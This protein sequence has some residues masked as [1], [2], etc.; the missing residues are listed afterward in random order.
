MFKPELP[1]KPAADASPANQAVCCARLLARIDLA[2]LA[3]FRIALGAI[4]LWEVWKYFT[5]GWIELTFL[6]G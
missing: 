3:F 6:A 5:L 1:A 2:S 4:L